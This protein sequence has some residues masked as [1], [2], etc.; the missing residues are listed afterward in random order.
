MRF[1][2][3]YNEFLS[4]LL[5][6]LESYVCWL[7][8]WNGTFYLES[9]THSWN[10]IFN[11][12]ENFGKFRL[13]LKPVLCS[14]CFSLHTIEKPTQVR[15]INHKD[16][17]YSPST[18]WGRAGEWPYVRKLLQNWTRP[19]NAVVQETGPIYRVP[20]SGKSRFDIQAKTNTQE[21]LATT[22][23]AIYYCTVYCNMFRP[24]F[25]FY[26]QAFLNIK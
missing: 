17:A 23:F 2:A 6:S 15:W 1:S 11:S 5:L 7:P 13:T 14:R 3:I 19:N 10:A 12:T 8:V 25:K 24:F 26:H 4:I 18:A 9:V 20:L 22:T 16:L 21:A